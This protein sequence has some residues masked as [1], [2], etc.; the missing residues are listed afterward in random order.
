MTTM[1]ILVRHGETEWNRIERFRGRFDVPL[2]ANGVHQ[3]Q[4]TAQYIST[5]WKP[6]AVY[7][8]PLSRA[9]KTAQFI[10][11]ASGLI[12]QA[13]PGLYDTNY[14]EWQGLTPA[15][16]TKRWPDLM[17]AWRTAPQTVTLPQG[18]SLANVRSRAMGAVNELVERHPEA[19]IV[20]A[21]HMD[22]IRLILLA[23]LDL[24][25]DHFRR[26]RQDNCAISLVEADANNYVVCS[27]NCHTHLQP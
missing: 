19:T 10:A 18:E 2:N 1:I 12:P 25:N 27:M 24:E 5:H 16:V 22:V 20:L 17:S 14:G 26:I 6:S 3:A 8:S 13:V 15:E 7:S 23:M 9:F 11:D 4:L 21:S